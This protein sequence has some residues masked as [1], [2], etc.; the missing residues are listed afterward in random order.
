[1]ITLVGMLVS[2]LVS[3]ATSSL[4]LYTMSRFFVGVF[5]SGNV[6]SVM[7]LLAEIVGPSYR[8][9]YSLGKDIVHNI[10]FAEFIF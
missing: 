6:L 7:T 8:G 10:S 1:M 9:I 2:N 3:A 4:F 5:V